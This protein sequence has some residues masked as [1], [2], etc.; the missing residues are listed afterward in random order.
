M[1]IVLTKV[2]DALVFV[3]HVQHIIVVHLGLVSHAS[4]DVLGPFFVLLLLV[5]LLVYAHVAFG[6]PLL[7][8]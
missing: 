5:D 1:N 3:G 7:A 8:V 6:H 4:Q 2:D